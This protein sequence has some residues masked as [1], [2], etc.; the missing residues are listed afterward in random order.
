MVKI[1]NPLLRTPLALIVD[2]SCPVINLTYHWIKQRQAWKA[3][4]QPQVG[5][6]ASDGDPAQMHK[7]PPTIPADFARKWGEWC[8]EAGI[9]GKFSLVPY[10]AGIARVD[11]GLPGFDRHEFDAWMNVYRTLIQPNFDVTCEMLTHS[12]V[13][14]LKTWQFTDA[15]EQYEWVDPPVEPSL[16]LLTDYIATAMQICR[17]AGVP[18]E[19][20][21]SPGAFG[22]KQESAYAKATLDAALRVNGDKRPFYFLHVADP[23]ESWPAV[24][25]WH[26]DKANGRA[27]ASIIGCTHDWFGSWTGY[28]AGDPDLFI[29]EDLQGGRLPQV[30]ARELPCVLVGH[31]PGFYFGGE[32]VGFDVLKEVKRRLDRYDPDQSKTIWMKTSEIAHYEMARQLSEIS[33]TDL[34]EGK[35]QITIETQ[36]PT[37]NFT[38]RVGAKCQRVQVGGVDLREVYARRDLVEGSFWQQGEVTIIAFGLPSGGAMIE[39][40][41]K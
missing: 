26:A 40:S 10:P 14:D 25:I 12:H 23:P 17:D 41:C 39:L 28:D 27:I 15:W 34:G 6:K 20:V 21:T 37:R 18:C 11:Q 8:G 16:E 2:D 19:G 35:W 36:F 7:V 32:E 33:T 30:L 29:T 13:V 4:F 24:P 5:F 1:E 9:K 31:W 3:K 22:S 38:L